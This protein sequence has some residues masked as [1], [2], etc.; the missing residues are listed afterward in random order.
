MESN[1][2]CRCL[3]KGN[4]SSWLTLHILVCESAESNIFRKNDMP[5]YKARPLDRKLERGLKIMSAH[6][7]DT[8]YN[9]KY[10]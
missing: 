7:A 5:F 4:F 1:G 3:H 9:Y 6:N 8:I 10:N 2:I